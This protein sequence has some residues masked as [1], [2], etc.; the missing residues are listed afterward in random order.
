MDERVNQ[1]K[2]WKLNVKLSQVR[3]SR[4]PSFRNERSPPD[5][6][7]PLLFRSLHLYKYPQQFS[8]RRQSTNPPSTNKPY[9]DGVTTACKSR[10]DTNLAR[11]LS[12]E[13]FELWDIGYISTIAIVVENDSSCLYLLSIS[14]SCCHSLFI[15]GTKTLNP[16]F[17]FSPSMIV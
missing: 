17:H 10:Y 7:I 2:P 6:S 13:G 15:H 14:V 16:T 3:Q 1:H 9:P 8:K 5:Y 11:A 12:G 4:Y